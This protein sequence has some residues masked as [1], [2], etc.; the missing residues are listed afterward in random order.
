MHLEK[1]A[2]W[3]AH[4]KGTLPVLHEGLIKRFFTL[5]HTHKEG[6]WRF[7]TH[8]NIWGKLHGVKMAPI[9]C[10]CCYSVPKVSSSLWGCIER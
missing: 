1:A 10:S 6:P 8:P 9:E 5:P 3:A 2:S 7:F 4:P